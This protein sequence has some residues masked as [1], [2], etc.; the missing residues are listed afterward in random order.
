[1]KH[2]SSARLVGSNAVD[3][4]MRRCAALVSLVAF[5]VGIVAPVAYLAVLAPVVR[6]EGRASLFLALVGVHYVALVLGN[7]HR[8]S[9]S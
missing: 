7:S 4:L 1:M 8:A 6:I 9:E 5:W 2:L 3:R